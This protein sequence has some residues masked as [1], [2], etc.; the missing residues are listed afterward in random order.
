MSKAV[1]TMEN[2]ACGSLVKP[3]DA[4]Q[5]EVL[6]KAAHD[7]MINTGTLFRVIGKVDTGHDYLNRPVIN[8]VI[9]EPVTGGGT[10]PF[11]WSVGTFRLA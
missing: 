7:P 2:V 9:V 6:G 3:Q 4:R 11:M 1:A 8:A 5:A 10:F